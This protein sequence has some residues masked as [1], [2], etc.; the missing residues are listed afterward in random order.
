MASQSDELF[1]NITV[2]RTEELN[3][4]WREAPREWG[5]SRHSL[6]PYVGSFPPSLSKYFIEWLSDN[7]HVIFDPFC[8]GGT[9][10]LEAGLNERI[11]I[12]N[13]ALHYATV[14]S[15][16]KSIVVK[17]SEL[18]NRVNDIQRKA[19]EIN[20]PYEGADVDDL[21][22][23]FSDYTLEQLLRWKSILRNRKNDNID[24]Y[25]DGLIC[26][27]LHGPSN[28]FLS[29]ST[30]DTYSSTPD[31]IRNIVSE[32]GLQ[33]PKRDIKRSILKKHRLVTKNNLKTGL[34]ISIKSG[35]ARKVNIEK[36]EVDLI[37]TSPPYLRVLDYTWNN[38]VRLWW[39]GNDRVQQ[40]NKLD[41]TSSTSKYKSFISD[42]LLEMRR[43]ISDDGFIVLVVGDVKKQLTNKSRLIVT[44]KIIAE[45]AKK[46]GLYPTSI[47]DDDYGVEGR[48]YSI[49][50]D[51]KYDYNT[52]Q[53]D[54]PTPIDRCLILSPNKNQSLP[55]EPHIN[56]NI[57]DY[58]GQK[59]LTDWS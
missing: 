20:Y 35:D 44:S 32:K 47:I 10:P 48:T 31:A 33:Y 4:S 23:Y 56:W 15:K 26:G 50:N 21:K 59:P 38:W 24:M 41:L 14:I 29:V 8:G 55:Q 27:V 39:L 16:A 5:H 36:N 43:V 2:K 3:D 1:P 58:T 54:I 46:V 11:G 30:K 40:R 9:V 52:E 25:I 28:M 45:Q 34:N 12:G 18:E 42:V 49:F 19:E 37:V 6:A 22:A 51:I 53:D 57:E 7:G 17:S 13:D